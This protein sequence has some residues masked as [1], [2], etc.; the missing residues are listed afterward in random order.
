MQGF[1]A[2]GADVKA[3]L[4]SLPV[5]L[6]SSQPEQ[7]SSREQPACPE[8]QSDLERLSRNNGRGKRWLGMEE[9]KGVSGEKWT[10][11]G[12][13][14]EVDLA[15]QKSGCQEEDLGTRNRTLG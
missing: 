11:G 14:W 4:E 1:A 6:H 10:G 2:F 15:P 12:V 13:W 8:N 9:A 3:T 7:E 5:R